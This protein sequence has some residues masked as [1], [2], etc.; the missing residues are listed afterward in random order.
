MPSSNVANLALPIPIK[1]F[2]LKLLAWYQD[3]KR[4]LPW[5]SNPDP[6]HVWV[7]E[8]MLQQ[9]QIKTALPYFVKFLEIYPSVET[10][11]QAKE[12]EVLLNWSGLGYYN[13]ARN[14][15]RTAQ[16]ICN[17]HDGKFPENYLDALQL[18]GIGRYTAGAILSIAYQKPLPIVDGNIQRLFIRYLKI[19]QETQQKN[20]KKIWELLGQIVKKPEISQN[21]GDFN[22]SLMEMGALICTPKNPDCK[23]CPLSTNCMA[24]KQDL[25]ASLP[26]P[27][28]RKKIRSLHYTVLIATRG[29]KYLLRETRSK[30]LPT[31]FWEF[32]RIFGRPSSRSSQTFNQLHRLDF[33]VERKVKTVT[34]Q[35]T[36]RKIH[37]HPLIVSLKGSIPPKPFIWTTLNNK[38]YPISSYVNKIAR[39]LK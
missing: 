29:G 8:I 5:R 32:P 30:I 31:G 15:H 12:N 19:E 1:T 28:K 14:L 18:P 26:L 2:A 25:Q 21:I 3:N 39:K 34:H 16:I 22:Q 20:P 17:Q 4:D 7:S 36:H 13:R 27:R 37:F 38:H 11:A 24:F 6:Y 23:S 33:K 10:L 9:T 35:I